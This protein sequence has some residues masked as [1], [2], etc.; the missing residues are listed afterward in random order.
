MVVDAKYLI[1]M[2]MN[3]YENLKYDREII[4]KKKKLATTRKL[5]PV[6]VDISYTPMIISNGCQIVHLDHQNAKSIVLKI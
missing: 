6:I 2:F 5:A 1:C 3:I 4:G